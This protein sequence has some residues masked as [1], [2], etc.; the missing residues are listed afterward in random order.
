M[1]NKFSESA[2]R[3]NRR[4]FLKSQAILGL[5]T[6]AA[7]TAIPWASASAYQPENNEILTQEELLAKYVECL[8]GPFPKP[9]TLNP[10]L[11]ETLQKDG[12]RIESFTYEGLPG[13]RIPA[14]ILIPDGVNA[15][16]P[17]PGIA[18]WHQ[19]KACFALHLQKG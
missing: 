19:V 13:E 5:G 2:S 17:A 3:Q 4:S 18:V 10:Q 8:G 7:G 12:Y 1:K 16:N 11:R 6:F 14:L 15:S 9:S